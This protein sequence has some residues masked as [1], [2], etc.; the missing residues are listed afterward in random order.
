MIGVTEVI[1]A[2]EHPIKS[3]SSSK[4]LTCYKLVV[5][6]F[7]IYALYGRD[8]RIV[9]LVLVAGA[10]VVSLSIVRNFFPQYNKS[11]QWLTELGQWTVTGQQSNIIVASGCHVALSRETYVHSESLDFCYSGYITVQS[12]SFIRILCVR[13]FLLTSRFKVS[14]LP[15]RHYSPTI[16]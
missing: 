12:V 14:L 10:V 11:P 6:F 1:V 4:R 7:R 3:R 15:G 2:G 9:A 8:R 13:A 16:C 5:Q